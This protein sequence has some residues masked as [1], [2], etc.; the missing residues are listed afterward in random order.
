M[1]EERIENLEEL[2]EMLSYTFSDITLLDTSLTHSS[3]AN[4]NP[5]LAWEDNER[6]E[7]LG[8]AVL[9]LCISDILIKRFPDYAEGQ[10]SKVRAAMVN[11]QPLAGLA[12]EYR[13][14]EFML[15]GRGEENSGGRDKDSILGDAV[16]A[17]I[18]AIYLDGGYE[19]TLRFIR[20]T[21]QSLVDEWIESPIYLDYKSLL[22]ETSQGRFRLVPQYRI[23]GASGPDHDKTFDIEASIGDIISTTGTGKNKKDAE[24][25]AARKALQKLEEI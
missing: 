21:F 9:Q 4:E 25:D 3:Y 5:D 20:A 19:S 22:Q 10:L 17:I 8:D 6:L 11:E 1:D 16:E 24:Q 14:G 23:T 12:R 13:I 7:F 18:G 15:L 2:S